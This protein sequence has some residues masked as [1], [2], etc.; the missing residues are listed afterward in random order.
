MSKARSVRRTL[1]NA[2]VGCSKMPDLGVTPL[3][4]DRA[5]CRISS[6]RVANWVRHGIITA[7]QVEESLRRMVIVVDGHNRT[8]RRTSRW[9]RPTTVRH[10]SP[11]VTWYCRDRPAVRLHRANPAPPTAG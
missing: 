11:P 6:Q 9:H 3:M 8:T 2:G 5:T 7:E 1:V 4:E 10:S